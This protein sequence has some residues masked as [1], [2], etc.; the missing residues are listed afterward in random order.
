MIW[1][2]W[3]RKVNKISKPHLFNYFNGFIFLVFLTSCAVATKEYSELYGPSS[4]K[5][6]ILSADE[7]KQNK[8]ISFTKEVLPILGQ[9]CA[10]CHSCNDAACQLHFTSLEGIDRG[11]TSVPVYNGA[12]FTQQEPTR[13]GI[14]ASSTAQWRGMGF[15]PVL[16]ER[17]QNAQINLDNSLLYKTLTAKRV[18]QFTTQGRLPEE[19][20]VGTSLTED[21][22]FV[23][24]QVCPAV[25]EYSSFT[26]KNPQF[27]MPFALPPLN[28]KEFKT[29]ET[30]LEQGSRSEP[31]KELS[32]NLKN[33]VKKWEKFL[34]G[35]SNKE[36]LMSRYL[37]E[38]LFLGH[39]YFKNV[40]EKNF[41][42]LVRS[43]TP[44]GAAIEIIGT[45]R[46]YNDPGVEKF[47]YRLK[48]YNR[49]IVDKNHLPYPINDDRIKR[50]KQL[51]LEPSYTV[52]KL[53]SYEPVL[54]A[55][56][57]KTY[58]AIPAK[59]RYQFMLDDAQFFV[60]GFIKG[61]V[62]RGSIALSV[63]DDHFWVAF[64]DPEKSFISQ[65]SKFLARVSDKLRMPSEQEN[66]ASL[67]S[68]W[69]TYKDD[70]NDYFIEKIKYLDKHIS[71]KKG[72]GIEQIW[73]GDHS[74]DNAALT[75]YRHYDSATV[76]KGFIGEIPKT[77]WVM[78]Y[79]IFER[80]HYLLVAGFDVYGKA[81]HQLST[82]LY[83]DFL[84]FEA[85]ME[86]LA[87]LPIK[88]RLKIHR[89]WY[90]DADTTDDLLNAMRKLDVEMHESKI[91]YETTDVKKEFFVKLT[92][93]LQK[94]QRS[95]GDY[96]NRCYDF[97]TECK[98]SKWA[99]NLPPEAKSLIELSGIKGARTNVFPNVTFMRIKIDG[100]LKKDMVFT[101]VRNKS[102]LNT[103]SLTASKDTRVK[104][105]DT[106]DIIPGFV[107]AYPNFFLEVDYKNISQ[108][109]KQYKEI[110]SFEKYD[111]LVDNYGIRRS[112][113]NFWQSSDWFYK[114]HQYDNSVYAGLFD[115]NRY[116][117]R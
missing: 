3:A 110:D 103:L 37:Y 116:K 47:Y 48:H 45:T 54:A 115:L 117:N 100:S 39:L 76:L 16:N 80:V 89:H 72:F 81:G 69:A 25:E 107:G 30:W 13:L 75:V 46:P 18:H 8:H 32:K 98:A 14:D 19:Y 94:A 111:A 109:V 28:N 52:D 93:H 64:M 90:R 85:E 34:N 102:Y 87:F 97:P 7:I 2:R 53:P 12:R 5:N 113:P 86:F 67:L 70:A 62:C 78:D 38:H 68:V 9:R 101:I 61:A 23:H 99:K 20:D 35:S 40:S 41:F 106:I 92:Q 22:S 26:Q 56:P 82:R 104:S 65:D 49:I 57:F 51:F 105:E 63:I 1:A 29:I 58:T 4:P 33:E 73:D 42:T 60:G 6:R 55:N 112:N 50:Y 59:N 96:L 31:K 79:P 77:G 66:S 36:Q 10:V 91:K 44:P 43:K 21:E 24:T 108:F 95:H 71:D 84:R 15:T 114:K 83:M 17:R 74:N 11:L 88:E 27:G